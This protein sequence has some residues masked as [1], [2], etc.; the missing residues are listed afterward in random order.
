MQALGGF[1]LLLSALILGRWGEGLVAGFACLAALLLGAA[2]LVP[3]ALTIII[4]GLSQFGKGVVIGWVWADTR[5]Q[6]P[7]L[8]LA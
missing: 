7:A 4:T 1:A 8:S 3:I 5:Q 2:L 6:I